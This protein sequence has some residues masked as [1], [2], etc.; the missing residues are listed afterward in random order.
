M[1]G[2]VTHTRGQNDSLESRE[3]RLTSQCW[4]HT[5][6]YAYNIH[7][8]VH[9]YT[10]SNRVEVSHL[11]WRTGLNMV[12]AL[13]WNGSMIILNPTRSHDGHLTVT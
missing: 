11:K 13:S 9:T 12:G 8:Y 3:N 1:C 6:T 7:T 5:T 4:I 10:Q 2:A